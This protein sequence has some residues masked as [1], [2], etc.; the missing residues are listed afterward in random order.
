MK[1]KLIDMITENK[2]E[3]SHFQM[4]VDNNVETV[5]R[6]TNRTVNGLL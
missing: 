1:N 6:P 3:H 2:A 4:Q 5:Y